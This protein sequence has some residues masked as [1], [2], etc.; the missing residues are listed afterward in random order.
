MLIGSLIAGRTVDYFTHTVG[1]VVSRNWQDFWV[2]S[3][4]SAFLI[5]LLIAICFRSS[6]KIVGAG[7]PASW[8][9]QNGNAQSANLTCYPSSTAVSSLE[10]FLLPCY[11]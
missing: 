8:S 6:S 4:W 9:P 5:L 2:T 10:S 11:R 7:E 1:T 3:S